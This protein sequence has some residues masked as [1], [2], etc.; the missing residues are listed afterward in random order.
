MLFKLRIWIKI[1]K[2]TNTLLIPLSDWVS[3]RFW[4]LFTDISWYYGGAHADIIDLLGKRSSNPWNVCEN[5][6]KFSRN[7]EYGTHVFLFLTIVLRIMNV[8][9]FFMALLFLFVWN[10]P[11]GSK[12]MTEKYWAKEE[13]LKKWMYMVSTEKSQNMDHQ[14][15]I[16]QG[17]KRKK[18]MR[19]KNKP[20]ESKSS[21]MYVS[22]KFEI[23]L[24][25]KKMTYRVYVF[26]DLIAKTLEISSSEISSSD[27][28]S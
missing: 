24:P 17:S 15:Q 9:T 14:T 13:W 10:Q 2:E 12:I 21:Y 27:T 1:K 28:S 16:F 6:A 19:K 20:K 22:I 4:K 23:K 11:N 26:F 25:Y 3:V 18:L 5:I 7:F 8:Y